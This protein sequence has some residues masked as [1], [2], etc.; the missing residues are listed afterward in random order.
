MFYFQLP[1]FSKDWP[2]NS[3][4]RYIHSYTSKVQV[5]LALHVN[6]EILKLEKVVN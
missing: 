1:L 3:L 2:L 6:S 4:K 5:V